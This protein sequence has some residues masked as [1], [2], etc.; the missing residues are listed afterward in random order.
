LVYDRPLSRDLY[1]EPFDE[2]HRPSRRMKP[3]TQFLIIVGLL[4]IVLG[5][6]YYV[7]SNRAQEPLQVFAA[8]IRRD[9]APWDGS[10]F[11]V[12]M[13]IE[14]GI[15]DV[16]IYQS[17]EMSF[18][19]AFSFPDATGTTGI[20]LLR[21]PAGV[22]EELSGK[23]SFQSVTGESPVEGEFDFGTKTGRQFKGRF[24]AQWRN[25]PILCG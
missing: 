16:S 10:A 19:A 24:I 6:A 4:I 1:Q 8:T 3:R 5:S 17:P 21:L 9:C 25:E 23:V 18:Q 11:T 15:I 2:I 14:D 22:P 12:S 20:A 7:Y 13:P